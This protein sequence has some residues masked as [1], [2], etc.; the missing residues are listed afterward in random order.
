MSEVTAQARDFLRQ[1][2]LRLRHEFPIALIPELV[3][4][5]DRAWHTAAVGLDG[6]FCY[7]FSVEW[8]QL[9]M[10]IHDL[11]SALVIRSVHMT[12]WVQSARRGRASE[13]WQVRV[14]SLLEALGLD[15]P[16]AARMVSEWEV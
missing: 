7:Q 3:T 13:L 14:E 16:A 10:P 8:R 4:V 12:P 6:V 11:W 1:A 9:A 5:S 15:L 2:A